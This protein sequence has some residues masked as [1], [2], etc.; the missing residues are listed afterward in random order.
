MRLSDPKRYSSLLKINIIGKSGLSLF[1]SVP[2]LAE[3]SKRFYSLMRGSPQAFHLIS[4]ESSRVLDSWLTVT[5][6]VWSATGFC[7]I[8]V[9]FI[10]W[11]RSVIHHCYGPPSLFEPLVLLLLQDWLNFPSL[12][13]LYEGRNTNDIFELLLQASRLERHSAHI[14][15]TISLGLHCLARLRRASLWKQWE[16]Y[17]WRLWSI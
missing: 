17:L 9:K 4:V 11:W 6:T 8:L 3:C 13:I 14:D 16:P 10:V 12:L 15:R 1:R 7:S 2:G 5:Y